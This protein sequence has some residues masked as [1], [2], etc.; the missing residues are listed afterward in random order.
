[1]CPFV[2]VDTDR[3]LDTKWR[4]KCTRIVK[5]LIG[6]GIKYW[7]SQLY[8]LGLFPSYFKGIADL[9]LQTYK[10]HV[11]IVPHPRVKDYMCA[12]QNITKS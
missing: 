10:G 12:M 2:S 9:V 3:V 8:L 11:T 4:K 6:N 5:S 7:I 1:M